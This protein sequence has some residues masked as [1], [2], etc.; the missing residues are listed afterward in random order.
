[1]ESEESPCGFSFCPESVR[2]PPSQ[3]R[4]RRLIHSRPPQ[5]LLLGPPPMFPI[6]AV[7][8]PVR[9]IDFKSSARDVV[10]RRL[11]AGQDH[12]DQAGGRVHGRNRSWKGWLHRMKTGAISPQSSAACRAHEGGH[13]PPIRE[14]PPPE[15]FG[16]KIKSRRCFIERHQRGSGA[17]AMEQSPAF[18]PP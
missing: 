8:F 4:E 17:G 11:A 9:H 10:I 18:G 16:L 12:G 1:M 3:P 7:G 2:P 15:N 14:T 5:Q 13:F 6:A